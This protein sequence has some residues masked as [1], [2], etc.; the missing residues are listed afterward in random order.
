MSDKCHVPACGRPVQDA[1]LCETC[2]DE[3]KE[4][5]T[6]FDQLAE[7]LDAAYLRQQR[8]SVGSLNEHLRDPDE[9]KVP[10]NDRAGRIRRELS[11]ELLRWVLHVQDA[12]GLAWLP[13]PLTRHPSDRTQRASTR[14]MAA[15]LLWAMPYFRTNPAGAD[16]HRTFTSLW[17]RGLR[18]VDRPPDLVYLGVCSWITDGDECPEDLYAEWGKDHARCRGCGHEHRVD[19]RRSVLIAAV[20]SQLANA[21][22]ISRGLSGLELKVTA[23]RIRQWKRRNR[24]IAHGTDRNGYPLYRVGDVI[25]L[26]LADTQRRGKKEKK[27]A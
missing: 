26:V 10:F 21:A 2:A 3:L 6:D 15:R 23:E 9:S 16:A 18:C 14:A 22:D 7:A 24:I 27:T 11:R 1:C 17:A 20:K 19:D 5:L 8:F 4:A 12:H 25:D 13:D